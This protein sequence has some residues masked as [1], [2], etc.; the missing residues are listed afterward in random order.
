[1]LL[2]APLRAGLVQQ[3][4]RRVLQKGAGDGDVLLPEMEADTRIMRAIASPD[5]TVFPT[6]FPF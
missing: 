4:D 1:M 3:Y 6:F 2:N 5:A